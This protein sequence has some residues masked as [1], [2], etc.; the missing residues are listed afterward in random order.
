M[1]MKLR[2]KLMVIMVVVALVA[3]TLV[4]LTASLATKKLFDTYVDQQREARTGQWGTVFQAYYAQNGSWAGVQSLLAPARGGR[5]RGGGPGR[6]L[7]GERVELADAGGRVVGDSEGLSVGTVMEQAALAEAVPIKYAGQTVGYMLLTTGVHYELITLEQEFYRSVV[8]AVIW[9]GLAAAILAA[10]LGIAFSRRIT[11]SLLQLS[12]A[13]GRLAGQDLT[14]RV[15]ISSNDEIGQLSE[16][17]NAM[18]DSLER[19]ERIR[20]NLVADVAHELRTPLAILRG[21]LESMQEEV[22]EPTPV[23]IASLHDEVLRMSRLVSDLQELSLAEAGKLP[24][25]R[26]MVNFTELVAKVTT[27]LSGEAASK[28][29]KLEVQVSSVLPPAYIDPDRIAQVTLNL[30]ANALRHTPE[31][32]TI[33]LSAEEEGENL[34]VQVTDTGSGIRPEDLSRIFDRFYKSDKTRNRAEG[35]AGLGLAI[36]KGFVE[37]HGGRIWVESLFGEGSSFYF[38]VPLKVR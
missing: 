14:H 30:L 36:A 26:Q 15:K 27:M 20:Q 4:A 34:H 28:G 1:E 35:G 11:S 24:L 25:R 7:S 37:A 6:R 31:G 13:A 38:T 16:A 19:N 21:N 32:G 18:A 22:V 2:G 10:G 33:R 8:W 23:V 29:V 17:F 12:A 9:G 3:T 5:G